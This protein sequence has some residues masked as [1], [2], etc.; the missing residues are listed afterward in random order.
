MEKQNK[1]RIDTKFENKQVFVK[2]Y[3]YSKMDPTFSGP[4]KVLENSPEHNCLTIDIQGKPT[5]F[6]YRDV[7]LSK[8]KKDV[9]IH[10]M[11]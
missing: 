4:Y 2:N 11:A 7:K 9:V 3:I 8:E 5:R 6:T 1:H 10:N